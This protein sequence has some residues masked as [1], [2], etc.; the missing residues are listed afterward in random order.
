MSNRP[1]SDQIRQGW[2]LAGYS[3]AVGD[4]GMMEHC[5]VL[6]RRGE[7]KILRVRKKVMGGGVVAEEIDV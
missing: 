1:L 6:H 4:S 2:E 5:F 3:S 7:H